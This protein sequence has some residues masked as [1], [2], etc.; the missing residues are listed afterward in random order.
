MSRAC[1]LVFFQYF[2]RV[3]NQYQTQSTVFFNQ[4]KK[5]QDQIDTFYIA[6]GGWDFKWLPENS[7]VLNEDMQSH[8]HY[9]NKLTE[10]V[11]EDEVLYLDPDI[12]VYDPATISKG[13][14]AI[15]TYDVAGILD[16]SAILP[17]EDEFDL[18]K[19]NEN[20]AVRRRFT[21]YMTFAKT[22]LFKGLDFTPIAGKYD[23]MGYLTHEVM[24]KGIKYFEFED[25][26]NTLRLEKDGTLTKD[27]WLDGSPYL[28]S[29]PQGK[30]KD[31]GYYHVRN[32]SVG[33]SMLKEFKV[34]REAYEARKNT[35]PFSEVIR[36]LFWQLMYDEKAGENWKEEYFPVF[37]DLG[38]NP[39][40]VEKY[41]I[42]FNE[43]YP[44]IKKL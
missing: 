24:K 22:E 26:R 4:V 11:T 8:W 34:N 39:D 17:L 21:P 15:E 25:D 16:N 13:F 32:S 6:N 9:L 36:L 30:V 1:V 3:D 43:Y 29:A 28:W 38:V 37:E 7:V 44:W 2:P 41:F 35:M 18:F 33:L 20:R 12:L 27:T 14:K 5:W 19:A 23:S 10:M 31:L 40:W 42:V